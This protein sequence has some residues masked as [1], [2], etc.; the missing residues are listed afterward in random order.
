MKF[1]DP[2]KDSVF[3]TLWI[4]GDKDIKAYLNRMIEYIIGRKLDSYHLG[5]NTTGVISYKSIAN[6][7]DILL[8]SFDNKTKINVE[9]NRLSERSSRQNKET[10]MNKSYIYLANY[11]NSFYN[12]LEEKSRYVEAIKVEQ[13]NFNNFY[14]EENK[15]ISELHFSFM[16]K[17]YEITKNGVKSHQIYLPRMKEMCYDEEEDIHNDFALLVCKS[18]EE[19]EIYIK[20]NKE[21]QAVVKHLKKLGVDDEFM[22]VIDREEYNRIQQEITLNHEKELAIQKGLEEGKLKGRKEGIKEGRKEGI[23]EGRIKEKEDNIKSAY[24]NG[25]TDIDLLSKTFNISTSKV[26]EILNL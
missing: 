22:A 2:T 21:R 16:D 19:M 26:K 8:V 6:E 9:M 1:I 23:K 12:D 24:I 25:I 7:V 20:G 5:P 11:V 13:V 10:V 18:Y 14:C 15:L 17:N 3:K 4:K